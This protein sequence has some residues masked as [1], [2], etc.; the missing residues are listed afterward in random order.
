MAS[1]FSSSVSVD[2]TNQLK[3]T[4]L[5]EVL[6][7]LRRHGY[8]G[9]SYDLAQTRALQTTSYDLGLFLGLSPATLDVITKDTKGDVRRCLRECLTKWLLKADDVE[10]KGGPT[11]SSLI[12]ALRKLGENEAADGIDMEMH[13]ACRILAHYYSNRFLL[14]VLPELGI[15]LYGAELIQKMIIP[16]YIQGESLLD[17]IQ[18]AVC[19]D[20]KKLETFADILCKYRVTADIGRAIMRDYREAYGSDDEIGLKIYLPKSVTSELYLMQLKLADTFFIVRS[21][22]MRNPQSPSI[23]II[24]HVLGRYDMT[25]RPQL[26]LR[27][28]VHN[29]LQLVREN[30]SLDDVSMLE[31]LVNE[32]NIEEAKLVIEEYKAAIEKLKMKLCQFLEKELLKVSSLLDYI[33]IIVDKDTGYSVLKDVQRL[34]SAVLSDDVRITVVR[35]DYSMWEDSKQE[36]FTNTYV[37]PTVQS[38]DTTL[39]TEVP[40][41]TTEKDEDQVMLL[42]EKVESIQKQL[43]EEKEFHEKEKQFIIKK[44]EEEILQQKRD[45]IQNEER[46]ATLTE[47]QEEVTG[48]LKHK[49]EQ[50]EELRSDNEL[51]HKQLEELEKELK[52]EKLRKRS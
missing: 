24:K 22:L 10:T 32:F 8:Y 33:T 35:S 13:P 29:I 50:Y 18:A 15:S 34:S 46:I 30:S 41:G 47:Q 39:T 37:G 51:T 38:K 43:E 44:Y 1:P 25:L 48:D 42:Q 11:I 23:D 27:K 49:T 2:P 20:Y 19:A 5:P 6:Q 21:I 26:A 4:D 16:R 9:T 14:S 40:A 36:S 3:I 28:D 7:L 17:E 52:G 12:S 31:Y 45:L